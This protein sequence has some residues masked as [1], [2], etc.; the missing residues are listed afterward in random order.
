[1]MGRKKVNLKIAIAKGLRS[2][3]KLQKNC[4]RSDHDQIPS[5]EATKGS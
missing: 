2:K 5:K 3:A 1:M 4:A